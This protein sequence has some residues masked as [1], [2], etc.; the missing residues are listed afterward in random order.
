MKS[1][2]RNAGKKKKTGRAAA[3]RRKATAPN[4][5]RLS[6]IEGISVERQAYQV[7]RL[8]LMS[9][10]VQPGAGLT[11]R[12][13]SEALG[14]SP[15]PVRE[16]LKRLDADGA[17]ISRNKSAFFVYDPDKIDFTEL[18]EIRLR[19]EGMAIRLA[20]TKARKA[21]LILLSK[22]NNEY[23][24][25]LSGSD[26]TSAYSLQVNF[27]FHFE[28]YKLSG[29]HLL[30]EMIETLWLRIGPTLQR[31]MPAHDDKSISNFHNRMLQAVANNDPDKAEEAL[32]DDLTTAYMAIIP[33]LH[34]RR[35]DRI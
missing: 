3:G 28:L 30:V 13:L 17:V 32:K 16:A 23:Q 34:D 2:A 14:V 25:I 26:P 22:I 9:G 33:Q 29:S 1:G 10:A 7:L 12:S 21:D 27:R 8:A 11:S 35:P 31:Y 15:T 19:L 24:Q 4:L 18:L 5:P 6:P 20:A